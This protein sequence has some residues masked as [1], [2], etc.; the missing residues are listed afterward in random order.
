VLNST[1]KTETADTTVPKGTSKTQKPS[2][3]Q[4]RNDFCNTIRSLTDI[5]V[6]PDVGPL[7]FRKRTLRDGFNLPPPSR[8]PIGTHR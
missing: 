2:S 8:E 5:L 7:K 6:K 4:D 3:P 1:S